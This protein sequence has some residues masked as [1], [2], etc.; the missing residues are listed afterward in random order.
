[1][2]GSSSTVVGY[3]YGMGLH[4]GVCLEADE[5]LEIVAGDRSAWTGLVTETQAIEINMPK[6]FGGDDRE[7]GIVGTCD[8][9]M[10]R[11]DQGANEYLLEKIGPPQPGFRGFLGLVYRGQITSN[12]PYIKNWAA[13]VRSITRGWNRPAGCWY[14]EKARITIGDSTSHESKGS[15]LVHA[16]AEVTAGG[17][18]YGFVPYDFTG[19]ADEIAAMALNIR[20]AA[21][22]DGLVFLQ[23]YAEET[24]SDDFGPTYSI[25]ANSTADPELCAA[26]VPAQMVCPAG[27]TPSMYSDTDPID[28]GETAPLVACDL[29]GD[30]AGMN[31]AHIIFQCL[32]DPVWGMGYPEELVDADSFQRAADALYDEGMALCL[33]WSTQSSIRQFT[34]IIADHAAMNYGQS[35]TTGMFEIQ[36]LRQ[37]Y[38]PGALPTFNKGNCKL[39]KYQRPALTDTTN[40]I[41][42]EYTDIATGKDASTA[43]VQNSANIAAQGRIVSQ[44]LSFPGI[45][46]D[47]LATRV[48][49]R[50]LQARSTPLWR[51]TLEFRRGEATYLKAGAPFRVDFRDTELGVM[52]VLRAVEIDFGDPSDA[53]ITAQCVEDVFGM[54]ESVYVGTPDPSPEPPS[55][56]AQDP[57]STL[58][59]LPY[60][61]AVQMSSSAEAQALPAD[62]GFV[63]AAA[64]RPP[65]VPLDFTLTTRLGTTGAY[66]AVD[67]GTFCPSVML[68][69]VPRTNGPVTVSYTDA[70]SLGLLE[71]GQTAQIGEGRDAECVR[72]DSINTNARTVTFARGC[73][74]TVPKEWP[75]GAR[76]WA[77]DS[78]Q[79]IDPERYVDGE[80]VTAKVLTNATGGQEDP[81]DA[82]M[83]SIELASRIARPYPPG[84]L[85]INGEENPDSVLGEIVLTWAHRDRILQADTIVDSD[86]SSIGPEAGTTYNAR[87]YV[88]EVLVEEQTGITG[89]TTSYTPAAGLLRIELES[90]RDGLVSWQAH[91]RTLVG[92]TMLLAED[93]DPITAENGD[94]IL[95]E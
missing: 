38:E 64:V 5:L 77:N 90:E 33:Q 18:S 60:R 6:L 32:T 72:I 29:E 24:G 84:K 74:D 81:A 9:M 28:L 17:T 15:W 62:V 3:R 54:P 79:A 16:G 95:M 27:Y 57:E 66:E 53:K 10:G 44:R 39:V 4:M 47:E 56:E 78:F 23:S 71:P 59:E 1:M 35:R 86:D 92:A 61:E 49:M 30:H 42:V 69:P 94:P 55:N 80:T 93:G 36:L 82:T 48:A 22:G 87:W 83:Q 70:S 85:L 13:R 8:V 46:T 50:E 58:Y 21:S 41:I 12:N 76:L 43:P 40:E 37:D 51:M 7:G 75:A 25:G 65:G 31:P 89:N 45:P 14:P 91:N 68:A 88:D 34:Q 11:P 20:N 73:G 63:A 2:G 26:R 67:N 19:D 52:V